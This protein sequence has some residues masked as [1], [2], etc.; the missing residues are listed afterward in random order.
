MAFVHDLEHRGDASGLLCG[1]VFG[2]RQIPGEVIEFRFSVFCHI[3]LYE[4]PIA[5]AQC[6][7]GALF[8]EFPV[9]E[10]VRALFALAG[11]GRR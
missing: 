7:A 5:L 1:Q 3:V 4:L 10:I 9:E 2:F 11:E 6:A 8:V